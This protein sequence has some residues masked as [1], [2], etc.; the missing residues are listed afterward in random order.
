M[1]KHYGIKAEGGHIG[2]TFQGNATAGR[3]WLWAWLVWRFKVLFRWK[4]R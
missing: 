2:T 4:V 3:N 1:P